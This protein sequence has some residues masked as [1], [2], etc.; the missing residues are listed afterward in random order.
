MPTRR[1]QRAVEKKT[2]KKTAKIHDKSGPERILFSEKFACP[3]SGFTIPEI[4]PRLF[5]FNNPYGAC[6]A[7]GGLGVEQH[8]DEELVIPDKELTLRK[9]A[10]APWAKSSS[11]YYLQTLTALA[12]STNSRSTPN[13]KTCRRRRRTPSCTAPAMTRSNSPTKT[14]CAPTTPRSRLRAS[15]PISTAV[16]RNR[17][18]MGTRRA[19]QIFFRRSLRRPATAIGSSRRRCASRSAASISAKSRN[20]RCAVPANGSRPCRRR[21]TRSRTRSPRAF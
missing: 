1:H 3:V 11:P 16:S 8:I 13:G 10:I 2:D 6:P 18:R 14:A 12:N 5:S 19:W 15:S 9:G 4:E 7:C 17:K 20:C 21:S